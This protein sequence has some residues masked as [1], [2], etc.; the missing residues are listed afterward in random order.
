MKQWDSTLDS[1][2]RESHAIVDGEIR[3]LDGPFSNGLMFPGDP[4]Y[5]AAE[6]I[7][8]RCALLQSARK[9]LLDDDDDIETE[10]IGDV[11]AMTDKQKETLAKKLNVLVDELEKYSK[12]IIPINAKDYEISRRNI[13]KSG[14]MTTVTSKKRLMNGLQNGKI[15]NLQRNP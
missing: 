7:N 10:Y 13:T 3:E 6:V 5:G 12:Q 15:R 1:R 14:I 11:S 8:C 9:A 2:T 4:S